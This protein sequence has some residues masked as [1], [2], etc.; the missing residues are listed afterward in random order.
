MHERLDDFK[1]Y[2]VPDDSIKEQWYVQNN[3]ESV[4]RST[5]IQYSIDFNAAK[6]SLLYRLFNPEAPE[7]RT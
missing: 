4:D 2:E 1:I 7:Y 5:Y 6:R 3:R